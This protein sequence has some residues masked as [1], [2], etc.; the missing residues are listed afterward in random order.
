MINKGYFPQNVD[1]LLPSHV[2]NLYTD[3]LSLK[4]VG[5]NFAE[6]LIK[7]QTILFKKINLKMTY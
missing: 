4:A 5:T 3:L 6:F 2:F 1:V 7:I